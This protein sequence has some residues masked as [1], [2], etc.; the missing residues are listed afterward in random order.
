LWVRFFFGGVHARTKKFP[1]RHKKF[2]FRLKFIIFRLFVARATPTKE[3]EVRVTSKEDYMNTKKT[4]KSKR[5]ETMRKVEIHLFIDPSTLNVTE[6]VCKRCIGCRK[7]LPSYD[8]YPGVKSQLTSR[9]RTC[10]DGFYMQKNDQHA[11]VPLEVLINKAVYRAN[12]RS[13][14]RR[15]VGPDLTVD[16][17]L[18]KWTGCC[19]NCN[20]ELTFDW[21]PRQNNEN[22]AIIDRLNTSQNRSYGCDNFEWKCNL[23]NMEKSPYDLVNQKQQEIEELKSLLDKERRRKS[24]G[25]PYS[26]IL[27]PG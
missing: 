25:I 13:R 20:A 8:F 18:R 24:E 9:C 14:F 7:L 1:P 23:C 21:I 15:S 5:K 19:A 11:K 26:S 27:I 12:R 17:A 2:F 16:E 3:E 10:Y 22:K 4:N 6:E